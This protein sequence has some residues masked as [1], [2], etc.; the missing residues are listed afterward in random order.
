M[1]MV[2]FRL[3]YLKHKQKRSSH[4]LYHFSRIQFHCQMKRRLTIKYLCVRCQKL[5]VCISIAD[6]SGEVRGNN[7]LWSESE[8]RT[9]NAI[10]YLFC[11]KEKY[12]YSHHVWLSQGRISSPTQCLDGC[13]IP[14][15]YCHH[16]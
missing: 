12:Y 10:V 16:P 6:G 9:E 8:K 4:C 7:N 15:G 2:I 5:E 14:L 13:Y 1:V 3:S 11:L